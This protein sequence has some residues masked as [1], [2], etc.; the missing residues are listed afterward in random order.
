MRN[1]LFKQFTDL[2]SSSGTFI[3][4]EAGSNWKCGTYE[5]DLNRAKELITIAAKCGADAVKFQTYRSETT[6]VLGAGSSNYLSKHGINRDINKIFD[7]LSMPY[8]MIPEL[9]NYAK[10]E[11]IEFMSTPFSVGDAKQDRK[12]TRLNSSHIPLSRMPSSA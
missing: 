2:E 11:N 10:N 8:E 7:D 1:M 9:A 5:D 6:Y 3:I 4:A 12:S